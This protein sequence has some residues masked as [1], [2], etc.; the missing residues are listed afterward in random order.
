METN[1]PQKQKEKRLLQ[2]GRRL[3]APLSKRQGMSLSKRST[4]T[5]W[6]V[7]PLLALGDGPKRPGLE[8]LESHLL[9]VERSVPAQ[10]PC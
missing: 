3:P 6:T 7:P 4:Q 10:S 8:G 5:G 9:P 1:C 2:E